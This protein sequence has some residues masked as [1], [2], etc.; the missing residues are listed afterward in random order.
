[1]L[2]GRCFW[3]FVLPVLE[4]CSAVWCSAADTHLKLLDRVVS[5]ACFLA[6]LV[7]V[8]FPIV[9]PWQCCVCCT[10]SG[11][12]DAPT[13]WRSTCALCASPGYTRCFDRTS[14]YLCASPLQNLAVPQD[15]YSPLSITLERSGWPRIRW[16]GI[17]GFQEQ[18]RSNAF[19]LALLLAPFLSSTIFNFSSFPL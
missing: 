15:F 4:Y 3:G 2:I 11:V 5:G 12:T 7:P 9:D 19:L 14:V 8:I 17:G 10:R 6:G 1:M 13:L 18:G 16:C